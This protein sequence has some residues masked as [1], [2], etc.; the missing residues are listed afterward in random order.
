MVEGRQPLDTSVRVQAPDGGNQGN[1]VG[2]ERGRHDGASTHTSFTARS[3]TPS[4]F[5]HPSIDLATRLAVLTVE[6]KH[7]VDFA[8]VGHAVCVVMKYVGWA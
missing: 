2:K 1:V 7:R 6:D 5:H 3:S 8:F 4:R